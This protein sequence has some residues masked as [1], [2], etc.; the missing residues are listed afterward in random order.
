MK[1]PESIGKKVT[2][3]TVILAVFW[4]FLAMKPPMSGDELQDFRQ[5]QGKKLKPGL[6]SRKLAKTRS[7]FKKIIRK[8]KYNTKYTTH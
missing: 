5:K 6:V 4:Q 7:G 3:E 8:P 1:P 2:R